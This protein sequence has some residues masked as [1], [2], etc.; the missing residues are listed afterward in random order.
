MKR[1][2]FQI[3]AVAAAVL[4]TGGAV[5]YF[6]HSAPPGPVPSA[7]EREP[8]PEPRAKAVPERPESPPPAEAKRGAASPKP[9]VVHQT[10]PP[11]S[12]VPPPSRTIVARPAQPAPE[13]RWEAANRFFE[14]QK[15]ALEGETDPAKRMRLI[16]AIAK[17]VRINTP[18]T[19]EWAMGLENPE[20]RR[21]ALEAINRDALVGIGARIRKD[22]EGWPEIVDTT[23][24]S[25]IGSTGKVRPGD[26]ILGMVDPAGETVG[27]QGLSMREVVGMLR[28]PA[29]S[30][31]HLIMERPTEDGRPEQFEVTVERSMI[32]VQPRE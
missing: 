7:P 3:L 5:R 16:R 24:M 11:A 29:G 23:V 28:G 27:F 30:E 10:P 18:A 19:L 26:H 9:V 17:N 25:A 12:F 32:V 1:R 2:G 6:W 15:K 14:L 22:R 8:A 21:A 13:S 31:A 4:A 20:E